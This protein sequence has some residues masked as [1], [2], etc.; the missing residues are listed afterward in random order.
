MTIRPRFFL[1]ANI[2]MLLCG[3]LAQA[4]H[5]AEEIGETQMC[6]PLQQISNRTI[7]DN[8]TIVLRMVGGPK[9]KRID[10]AR[11]CPGLKS[12][13]GFASATSISR[14]CKQDILRVIEEPMGSQ[15]II[16]RIVTI[17]EAEAKALMGKR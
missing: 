17:D 12:A 10:L 2:A 4:A 8:R 9:Y 15:C 11:D 5:A 6:V 7:I 1:A 3:W 14:L 13:G 16:E